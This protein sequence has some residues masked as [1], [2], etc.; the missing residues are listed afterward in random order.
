MSNTCL[1]ISKRLRQEGHSVWIG[2]MQNE[3]EKIEKNKQNYIEV[4]QIIFDY[5]IDKVRYE[6]QYQNGKKVSKRHYWQQLEEELDF[7]QFD[8]LLGLYQIDLVLIDMELHEY[9]LHLQS[10]RFPFILISQW[11]SIWQTEGNIPPSASSYPKSSISRKLLW[12]KSRG[13][14]ML[15][16]LLH[17]IKYKGITRK[18]FLLHLASK[19]GIDQSQMI[20]YQFPLPFSYR[21]LPVISTTHP[22]L[23][24]G[25]SMP[26]NVQFV[27]PMVYEE[28][29]ELQNE[30]FTKDFSQ[31]LN[32]VQIQ[33]KKLILVTRSSMSKHGRQSLS[34]LLEVL[35][36]MEECISIISLGKLFDEYQTQPSGSNVYLYPSVPQ[37]TVLKN[38]DLSIHHGGIHTINECIHFAVPMLVLSGGQFDQNSCAVRIR[39]AGC[40]L[41]L[42]PRVG[43][44]KLREGIREIMSNPK[45]QNQINKLQSE[46]LDAKSEKA[47]ESIINQNLI[48]ENDIS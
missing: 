14:S 47:L 40:G 45:Y 10:Q 8:E 34:D 21:S 41:S 42:S 18:E 39:K 32:Q 11:F 16:S 29:V 26:T 3:R 46:Y 35:S 1:E 20:S 13:V 23:E 30:E 4:N 6:Q 44:K 25:T 15:K 33:N 2:S 12:A 5:Q 36:Q 48:S 38:A 27:Y 37:L 31:I 22:S 24:L 17:W 19:Y 43:A 7:S 9:I 28:R